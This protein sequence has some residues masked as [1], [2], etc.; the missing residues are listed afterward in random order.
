MSPQS[1]TPT[2]LPRLKPA[3]SLTAE[4]LTSLEDVRPF[5]PDWDSLAVASG[6][7]YSAPAWIKAWW[8]FLRPERSRLCIVFV[9]D[10]RRLVGVA[11]FCVVGGIYF[12]AGRGAAMAEPLAAGGMRQQVGASVATALAAEAPPP[13][14]VELGF[15]RS[16]GDWAAAIGDG[17]DGRAAWRRREAEHVVPSIDLGEGFEEWMKAKSSSFRRE[18]RRKRKKLDGVGAEFRYSD[19]TS[20]ERD[21]TEF[22]RL[23]RQRLS[24]QGGTALTDIG[25]EQM[26]VSAGRELLESGRFRLLCLEVE[27]SFVAAQLLLGAGPQLSAWNSGFDEEYAGL[28]PSMQCLIRALEDA[29]ERGER[30]MSLGPGDQEYKARLADSEDVLESHLIVP[31]GA[32]YPLVRL[33]IGAQGTIRDLRAAARRRLDS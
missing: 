23:H 27:G 15:R 1:G 21:V 9:S 32:R 10:A 19:A 28:S 2:M 25:I 16:A 29:S 14:Q 5:E 33:G 30:T 13:R 11:P 12:P 4:V 7:P 3:P 26:L 22:M 31:R 6:H 17:W 20:L 18:A 24:G 8:E